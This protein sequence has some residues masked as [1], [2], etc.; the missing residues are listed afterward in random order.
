VPS[1]NKFR[2][3]SA[4]RRPRAESQSKA[5]FRTALRHTRALNVSSASNLETNIGTRFERQ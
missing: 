5:H 4:D 2:T 3:D 1:V